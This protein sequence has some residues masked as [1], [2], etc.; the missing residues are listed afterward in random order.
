[1]ELG[2]FWIERMLALR[3]H[4]KWHAQRN[5][6]VMAG[7]AMAQQ[8]L[9][10]NLLPVESVFDGQANIVVVEGFDANIH[11]RDIAREPRHLRNLDS[12]IAL[13]LRDGLEVHAV[14]VIYI[15]ARQRVCSC[16]D[17]ADG[18]DL[19]LVEIG[20]SIEILEAGGST[21]H[22]RIEGRL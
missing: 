12:R 5:W 14:D 18:E 11:R 6:V 2:L 9:V 20:L 17:I 22:T 19:D 1:M 4:S 13:E 15:T 10:D 21:P 3:H 7:R 16:R 8:D